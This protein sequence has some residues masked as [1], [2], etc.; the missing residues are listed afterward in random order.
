[1]HHTLRHTTG[2]LVAAA[3]LALAATAHAGDLAPWAG[4]DYHDTVDGTPITWKRA[5]FTDTGLDGTPAEVPFGLTLPNGYDPAGSAAY[6]VVVYL[7]GSGAGG[8]DNQQQLRRMTGQYFARSA[9]VSAAYNAFV[10]APQATSWVNVNWGN[11]TYLQT[12]A[13]HTDH[14]H[15]T[16]NL[17]RYLTQ[18]G[19]NADLAG[20]LGIRAEHVD[21]DRIYL[22]GDSAGACGV[23]EMASRNGGLFAAAVEAHGT[24]PWNCAEE[25]ARTPFWMIHSVDDAT[26]P[27]R[28]I[29]APGYPHG[30]GALGILPLV[31]P[32]WGD[33]GQITLLDNPLGS[34]PPDPSAAARLIYTEFPAGYGH[35]PADSWTRDMTHSDV[36]PWLFAQAVPEP[37]MMT[38]L[39]LGGGAML[40]RRRRRR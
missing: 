40:R 27:N 32:H 6:P 26:I 39:A 18:A 35:G 10:L 31:D 29:G 22:V 14:N 23:F 28:D 15:L 17:L 38:L 36:R 30:A 20:A 12:D 37:G 8:T 9:Q 25:L 33:P 21:A 4:G 19:H 13:T 11:G 1:M 7:H 24:G 16:A 2:R 34:L 3:C 5:T